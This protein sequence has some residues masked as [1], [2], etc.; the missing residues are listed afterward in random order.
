MSLALLL[1]ILV[2]CLGFGL[3]YRVASGR[4]Q[5][6]THSPGNHAVSDKVWV[7]AEQIRN[8]F[9]MAKHE[10]FMR[11]AI[12][13]SRVAGIE[14]RTGGAFGSV[15]V[16]RDG[17]IVSEGSNHVVSNFDPT[18]H[19]EMEAIR[20]ASARLKALKL[21]GCILYTSS[22]PCP[23]C[24]ATAYWA[25]LD[26]IIYGAFATDSKKYGNFDDTFIYE[27]F[28]KPIEQRKIPEVQILRDE[29]VTVWK[30][31]ASL[32]DNVPY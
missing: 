23:M 19:G 13:G 22:E 11:R 5:E 7:S 28:A 10:E 31:Y 2:L 27:E 6:P 32:P 12:A 8:R 9:P 18:W 14:K 3:G 26:G 17:H 1:P 15:I 20:V 16:D 21:E 4:N 29:A 24:L 30:E 25:G